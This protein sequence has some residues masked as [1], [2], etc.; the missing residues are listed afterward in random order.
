MRQKSSF[1]NPLIMWYLNNLRDLPWRKTKDPFYIWLSE[2]ILQQ[3]RVAQGTSFYEKFVDEFDDIFALAAADEKHILKLWQGLGYYSRARNLHSAAKTVVNE[4]NGTFPNTY[5]DLL[6][7]KGI[8]DY[9]ASA[10]ASIAFNQ[11]HA[12][13]DGN[14]YRVLSRIFGIKT[15]INESKGIAEFKLLAQNLL[16]VDDPGTHNQALME[17]GAMVCLP[18]KPKCQTCIFN[19][20]CYAFNESKTDLLPV[21]IK[22]LKVRKRYFNYLVVD[23]KGEATVIRQRL[24]KDIWQNLYEFPLLETKNDDFD[25]STFENFIFQELSI[26]GS[27]KLRKFNEIPVVHKLSHQTL[28][29]S[30]W[31]IEPEEKVEELYPWKDLKSLALPVLLQNFVD[32]YHLVN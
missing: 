29:A 24:K 4:Y 11:P 13:V 25:N 2:I 32:K 27:F 1:S 8:G 19:H 3:T 9:T 30:F 14:V 5:K 7:L 22:K 20:R 15:P 21:K 18:Q 16:D 26:K 28:F 31:I 10:I 23:Y 12:V 6:K 17:F